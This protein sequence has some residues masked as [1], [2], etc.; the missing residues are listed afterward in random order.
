MNKYL[1]RIAGFTSFLKNCKHVLFTL[2]GFNDPV[3][4]YTSKKIHFTVLFAAIIVGILLS[5]PFFEQCTLLI[6]SFD[7]SIF[8]TVFFQFLHST[9]SGLFTLTHILFAYAVFFCFLYLFNPDH[10]LFK[11]VRWLRCNKHL[12]YFMATCIYI[13]WICFFVCL[14]VVPSFFFTASPHFFL[15]F[16]LVSILVYLL[17]FLRFTSALLAFVSKL[18]MCG[19]DIALIL[20]WLLLALIVGFHI[21]VIL[22]YILSWIALYT[23]LFYYMFGFDKPLSNPNDPFDPTDS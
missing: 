13:I 4:Q 19:F 18:E 11:T 21:H 9:V 20:Q 6:K 5:T 12:G 2:A 15:F 3:L 23:D 8:S 7:E 22:F 1:S 16:F 17:L 10:K 14:F